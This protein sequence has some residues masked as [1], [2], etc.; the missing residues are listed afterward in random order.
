MS[1]VAESA[2]PYVERRVSTNDGLQLYLRD[3]GDP[4]SAGTTL[5]CLGGLTR[6]SKDFD[7][8]ARRLCTNRRVVTLDLRGRGRSDYDPDWR[9]YRP[10]TYLADVSSV[11]IA[12]NIHPIVVC[13][14]SL[15]GLLAMGLAAMSPL[16]IAGAILND[17][18]PEIDGSGLERILDYIGTDRPQDDWEGAVAE[19]K[20]L[21][22][23]LGF[24]SEEEWRAQAEATYSRGD[25][26]RLH[27]DWDISLARPLQE[28][29]D[30]AVDLWKLFGAL[31]VRPVLALRGETS[32]IL[33]ADTLRRMAEVK[34]DLQQ[35]T[36]PGVGH[37]PSL[38]EHEAEQ[39]IDDFL[40]S[41]DT[42]LRH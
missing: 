22:P 26:G 12:L 5:L 17:V 33:S 39:A 25:D 24:N 34:R 38:N 42:S 28:K 4:L 16:A 19:V 14:T 11:L 27:F 7:V 37:T 1:A 31:S 2:A 10:A 21:Y 6:N 23:Q 36:V 29:L 3:Y 18:G 40:R 9:N 20:R 32:D 41:I 35:V 8:L 13:G 30:D 15:G